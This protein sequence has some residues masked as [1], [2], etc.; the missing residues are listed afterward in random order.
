MQREK[1]HAEQAMSLPKM[2]SQE[3]QIHAMN[4]L[5]LSRICADNEHLWAE[6]TVN[7]TIYCS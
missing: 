1:L 2:N 3:V 4:R 7:W 6:S 5:Q